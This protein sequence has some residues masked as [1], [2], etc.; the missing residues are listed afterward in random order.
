M[1]CTKHAIASSPLNGSVL[2]QDVQRKAQEVVSPS[3]WPRRLHI[4]FLGFPLVLVCDDILIPKPELAQC[5]PYLHTFMIL[6]IFN[7]FGYFQQF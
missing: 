5:R 7:N 1:T 6:F 4:A 3:D 2:V